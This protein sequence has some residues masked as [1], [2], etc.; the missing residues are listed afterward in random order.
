MDSWFPI[1]TASGLSILDVGSGN[2]VID[3]S[4]GDG[5]GIDAYYLNI[6]MG[7]GNDV[8]SASGASG[9]LVIESGLVDLGSGK[10]TLNVA[11][12]FG[13]A[14][15]GEF[16]SI[17]FGDAKDVLT[18]L[19]ES[20]AGMVLVGCDLNM[21]GGKNRLSMASS[22]NGYG[23]AVQDS[24]ISFGSGKDV[25]I[26]S[27]QVLS[28]VA[29]GA[30][31]V[32][33]GGGNDVIDFS[34]GAGFFMESANDFNYISLGD[35][36]DVLKGFGTGKVD[37]GAGKDKLLLPAAIYTVETASAAIGSATVSGFNLMNGGATLFVS[38][39][40]QVG[41]LGGGRLVGL[42]A[43]ILDVRDDDVVLFAS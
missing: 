27:S 30:S 26:S 43:G 5:Y 6:L 20:S 31:Q 32:L 36:K 9:A 10:N 39:M 1:G 38:G 15:R 40:E 14:L 35:G 3:A 16:S 13:Q 37:A 33:M 11:S 24:V 28:F 7:D 19:S 41:Y 34:S 42:Q 2:D 25:F 22:V 17:R 18:G 23:S 29:E 12:T 21:G 4:G 8:I